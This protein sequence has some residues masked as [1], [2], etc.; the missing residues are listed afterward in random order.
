MPR[1]SYTAIDSGGDE[2]NGGLTAATLELAVADLKARG[3]FPTD[4][5]EEAGSLASVA[6][7]KYASAQPVLAG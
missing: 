2:K 6:T 4:I 1:F 3:F 5:A 7:G